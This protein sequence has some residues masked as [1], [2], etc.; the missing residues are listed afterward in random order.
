MAKGDAKDKEKTVSDFRFGII[1]GL[2]Y[3][4]IPDLL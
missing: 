1:A 2:V 4:E 3:P